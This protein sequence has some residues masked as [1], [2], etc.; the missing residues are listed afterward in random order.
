M[1]VAAGG[2]EPRNKP[3]GAVAAGAPPVSAA[4]SMHLPQPLAWD[5]VGS[6]APQWTHRR[7][8]PGGFVAIVTLTY[9][10]RWVMLRTGFM[11][12]R[13][14]RQDSTKVLQFQINLGSIGHRVGDPRPHEF[15]ETLAKAMEGHSDS[16][17]RHPQFH[18]DPRVR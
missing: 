11:L 5:R 18:R 9:P 17:G 1:S 13:L 6:V 3:D 8:V 2:G 12:V 7:R 16:H 10:I 14:T 4:V 15:A